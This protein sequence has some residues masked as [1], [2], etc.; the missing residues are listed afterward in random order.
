M[1]LGASPSW[2]AMKQVRVKGLAPA[3]RD[4]NTAR[5]APGRGEVEGH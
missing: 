5:K 1:L 2:P 3:P 4:S